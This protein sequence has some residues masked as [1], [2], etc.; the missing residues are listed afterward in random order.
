[1]MV[2]P[3][4]SN[5]IKVSEPYKENGR[6]YI[7]VQN[8]TNNKVRKVRWYTEAEFRKAYPTQTIPAE[9]TNLLKNQHNALGFQKGYIHLF[10]GEIT[11]EV[12]DWFRLNKEIYFNTL[13]GWFLP[14]HEELPEG[15]P[16]GIEMVKLDWDLVANGSEKLAPKSKV[17]AVVAELLYPP[18]TSEHLGKI[19]ERLELTLTVTNKKAK[20]NDY[21]LQTIHFF[22]DEN[23]NVLAWSTAAKSLEVGKTYVIRG[24]VKGYTTFRNIK[25]TWLTR[26]SVID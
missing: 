16:E 20:E 15:M 3:S 11:E 22:K 17:E 13:F 5:F 10:K 1:M 9:T 7:S 19:G 25:T 4:F 18:S 26:C 6:M 2:A 8:P 21:G 24:T 14:S 23:D 12:E